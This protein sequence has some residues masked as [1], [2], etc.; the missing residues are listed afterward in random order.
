MNLVKLY[1]FLE[2][3]DEKVIVVEYVA[4]GNLREHLD[5]LRGNRLEMAERLEIAIDVA[6]ALTYLH[7]YTG[8]LVILLSVLHYSLLCQDLTH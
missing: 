8:N 2:H 6:H 4:N 7:T 3:G 5:G 1:G